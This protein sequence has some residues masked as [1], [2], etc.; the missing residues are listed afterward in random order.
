MRHIKEKDKA[1]DNNISTYLFFSRT[2]T[3]RLWEMPRGASSRFIR[4]FQGHAA[5]V[6]DESWL[7]LCRWSLLFHG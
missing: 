6:K 3:K 2:D 5:D 7:V 4:G 1:L